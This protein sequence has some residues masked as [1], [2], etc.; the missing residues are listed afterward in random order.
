MH[1]EYVNRLLL[2]ISFNLFFFEYDHNQNKIKS[3]LIAA[4]ILFQTC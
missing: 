1:N 3:P 2:K 4:I